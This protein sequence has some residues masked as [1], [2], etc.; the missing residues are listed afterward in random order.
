MNESRIKTHIAL[1]V[2]L[3]ISVVPNKL[4]FAQQVTID[5]EPSAVLEN[6]QVLSL[7]SLGIDKD[8]N[9]PPL[10]SAT[11]ENLSSEKID[12]LYLEIIISAEKVGNLVEVT[13]NASSSF[14]LRPNQSVYF[15]NNHL[16]NERI[17]GI[18]GQITFTGGLTTEGDNFLS[19]LS[20]S[21]TL[22]RD[23]YTMEITLFRVTD[24]R[25]REDLAQDV[26]EIV[27]GGDENS[28][29]FD[30]SE[31]YLKTPGDIIGSS[32][33]ITNPFPQFSWEGRNNVN[34]RLLVVEER[35]QDSPESLMEGAKSSPPVDD[36]GS[37]LSF[38]NLDV[39]VKGTS[40]QYPSSGAQPL[41][42]GKTYYWRVITTVK[43]NNDNE[44]ISSE[45]W[46][47][48]LKDAAEAT[49]TAS[50][51][52]QVQRALMEL[53]GQDALRQLKDRG[54]SLE[55]IQYD[56]QEFTGPAAAIKL[57]EILE[58]IRDED[59]IVNGD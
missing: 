18:Q 37:L 16:R 20:G 52:G 3:L 22:P 8:G 23:T 31:V 43:G 58:K 6:T 29:A 30:E 4:L 47:F 1:L 21:T 13:Q 14:A 33:E 44:V 17:P 45:I 50:L 38:E 56:G 49:S 51:T 9:G 48:T 35:E 41:E 53:I 54:F 26:A 11:I 25:G 2:L 42:Q 55:S 5:L 36:G 32:S 24:A 10:I 59:L 39:T 34:Y 28:P 19:D 46:N 27:G 12:N 15:T 40:F 57:E 7:S